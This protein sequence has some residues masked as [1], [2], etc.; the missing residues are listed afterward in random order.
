MTSPLLAEP[1][2]VAGT[3]PDADV[4]AH[5]GDPFAEQR[6]AARSVVVV[7]RSNRGVIAIPG[8]DRVVASGS[9]P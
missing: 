2:A 9:S 6:S 4:A 7:D 5:Y 8:E 1:G 3:A